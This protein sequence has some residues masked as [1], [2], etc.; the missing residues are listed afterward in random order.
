MQF[1]IKCCVLECGGELRGPNGVIHVSNTTTKYVSNQICT[2]NVTVRSGRTISVKFIDMNFFQ[3]KSCS[4]SYVMVRT[5]KWHFYS[6][7]L[8]SALIHLKI[9]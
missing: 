9:S 6:K 3:F 2:W 1:K 5:C 4:N 8:N 7:V